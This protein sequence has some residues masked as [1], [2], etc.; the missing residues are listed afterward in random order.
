MVHLY[1]NK[2]I[3]VLK[4]GCALLNLAEICLQKSTTGNLVA[5]QRATRIFWEKY[6]KTLLVGHPL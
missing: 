3:E 2:G 1:Q 4:L 5:S 6:A